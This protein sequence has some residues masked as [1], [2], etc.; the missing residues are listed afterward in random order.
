MIPDDSRAMKDRLNTL[1][2]DLLLSQND[3][4]CQELLVKTIVA[5]LDN[6]K[7][8]ASNIWNAAIKTVIKL[9]S[10]STVATAIT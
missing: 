6:V 9:L 4:T 1:Y 2:Q 3:D 8:D 10:Y 7:Q 5:I